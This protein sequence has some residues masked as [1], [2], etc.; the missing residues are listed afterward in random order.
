MDRG[1]LRAPPRLGPGARGDARGRR[2][3]EERRDVAR[4]EGR[5]DRRSRRL[6]AGAVPG[7][8][9][10]RPDARA[11]PR[12]VPVAGLLVQAPARRHEQGH[13]CRVPRAVG[14]GDVGARAAPRRGRPR[15]GDRPGRAP[16]PQ[17]GGRRSRRSTHLREH[18]RGR[19][20]PRADRARGGA[21]RVRRVPR[22]AGVGPR[23][24]ALPRHRHG[25]V[26]R[27]GPRAAR[28]EGR[29]RRVQGRGGERS[30][31]ERRP[32][33]RRHG[34]GAAR[35]EP[36]DDAGAGGRRR[37]GRPVRARARRARRHAALLRSSSRAPVGAWRPRGRAER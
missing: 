9:A 8:R 37:D 1:S 3:G 29:H 34:A 35:P 2:R 19:L 24:G 25:D 12:P 11:A 27:T 33:R 15:A 22:G 28:L 32:P 16:A 4:A 21:D 7:R 26:H 30:P 14:G 23:R 10:R 18:A 31:R 36:R 17:R 6:P 5:R 20:E 13:L